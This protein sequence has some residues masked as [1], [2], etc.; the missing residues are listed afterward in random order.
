MQAYEYIY[1]E[2]NKVIASDLP[3]D[4]SPARQ[5]LIRPGHI[6]RD[7]YSL[8]VWGT[9]KVYQF[10][11]C[12]IYDTEPNFYEYDTKC[13]VTHKTIFGKTRQYVPTGWMLLRETRPFQ[14][15]IKSYILEIRKPPKGE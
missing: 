2:D 6:E 3:L 4:F 15:Y 1:V 9:E 8:Q 7:S 13:Y 5:R 12:N 11:L 10:V 14:V